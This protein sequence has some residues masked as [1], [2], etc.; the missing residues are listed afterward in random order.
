MH[1]N[2]CL[3]SVALSFGP[4]ANRYRARAMFTAME[5]LMLI[6]A[7]TALMPL[8]YVTSMFVSNG[9]WNVLSY[10]KTY[11][12][13]HGWAQRAKAAHTNA[14]ENLVLFATMVFLGESFDVPNMDGAANV[15][16]LARLLHWPACVFSDRIPVMRTACFIA[17]WLAVMFLPGPHMV[18]CHTVLGALLI[19]CMIW[20]TVRAAQVPPQGVL[21]LL[22][23]TREADGMNAPHE[24]AKKS[25]GGWDSVGV[26]VGSSDCS[27][28]GTYLREYV[29]SAARGP[30]RVDARWGRVG[31]G[32]S[33]L[34]EK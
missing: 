12:P 27:G 26:A 10:N 21:R 17:G 2:L 6:T 14:I 18:H 30:R 29:G 4:R 34:G 32:R 33:G 5:C 16:L 8:P 22:R 11:V 31:R 28:V 23:E 1:A 25:A 15:Y 9:V 20:C 7:Y 24:A 13:L 19:W 3:Q